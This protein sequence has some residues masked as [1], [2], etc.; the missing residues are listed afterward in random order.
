MN[1][2][3]L[4]LKV[5]LEIHQQL[6]TKKLFCNCP[7]ILVESDKKV[8]IRELHA[9]KSEVGEVDIAALEEE[10]K[11]RRYVYLAPKE[12]S[13]LVE[14]DEEPPHELNRE[15]LEI[16]LTIALMLNAK[17]IDE[18]RFM[19]KIVID[20]SNPTG[21]QRTALIAVD[22]EIHGIKIKTICLEEEAARKIREENNKVIYNLDRMGIPLIERA[23]EPTIDDPEKA[24]EVAEAIGLI[25]RSTKRVKRGIGT[26]RQDLNVSIRGGARVEI[27]GVQE[28]DLIP[29]II[30]KE[31]ERQLHMLRLIEELKNRVKKEELKFEPK[32]LT[33][34]FKN[35]RS[36]LIKRALDS[37]MRVYG[38][39]LKGMRGL[40]SLGG[41]YRLG[42]DLAVYVKVKTGL[43]GIIHS[44]ELPGYGITEE[45]IKDIMRVLNSG[46]NDAFVL[47]IANEESALKALNAVYERVLMLFDGVPAE[48]R[49][50]LPDG[51]TEYMRPLPGAARMY[52]ETDVPPIRITDDLLNK[53]RENIPEKF[54]EKVK[55]FV[56]QYGI[57]EDQA[58]TI[59]RRNLDDIFEKAVALGIKPSIVVKTLLGTIEEV[60]KDIGDIKNLTEDVLMEVFEGLSRNKFSK[61]AIPEILKYI[62]GRGYR[63]I[64]EI[65]E[66]LGLKLMSEDE[67]RAI[68]REIVNDLKEIILKRKMGA[69]GIVMGKVMD[70]VRGKADG[71]LVS[72]LVKEE[73]KKVLGES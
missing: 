59:I 40:L 12:S 8:A 70:I 58:K 68:I 1:Y 2:R 29:T 51:N 65:C 44:D 3:E 47:V 25:L 17:I 21:F 73:I 38:L 14:L 41:D 27:K 10:A 36:K 53:L 60:R 9:V 56:S 28:L 45:E 42:K 43:R 31:V 20:G 72:K 55:R 46:E 61:E 37:G 54:E 7:S 15:A 16:A 11:G 52:P 39:K 35:T 32:D 63:P 5:G 71:K 34:L 26:I 69:M 13:C 22:G 48:V 62:A 18:V 30:K 4:G 19:R 66:E 57:H 49:R 23:T 6:D 64:D 24:R 67:V 50:A 33:Y